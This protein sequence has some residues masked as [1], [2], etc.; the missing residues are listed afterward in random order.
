[1]SE[2]QEKTLETT[3]EKPKTPEDIALEFLE[4]RKKKF[5]EIYQTEQDIKAAKQMEQDLKKQKKEQNSQLRKLQDDREAVLKIASLPTAEEEKNNRLHF[6]VQTFFDFLKKADDESQSLSKQVNGLHHI[7]KVCQHF[8]ASVFVSSGREGNQ[9]YLVLDVNK[10]CRALDAEYAQQAERRK[11]AEEI[12]RKQWDE[13]VTDD[14][15]AAVLQQQSRDA[16][17]V[18]RLKK[19]PA[20]ISGV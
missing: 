7:E 11:Q 10:F 14:R 19:K 6:P 5:L 16:E 1:M 20:K 18:K 15:V 13:M 9:R 8:L 3:E 2:E 4:Q 12:L 17:L